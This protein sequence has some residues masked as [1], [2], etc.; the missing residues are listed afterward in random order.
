MP[1]PL[2]NK[3]FARSG[4]LLADTLVDEEGVSVAG[5][6]QLLAYAY[7]LGTARGRRAGRRAIVVRGNLAALYIA[8]ALTRFQSGIDHNLR[9]AERAGHWGGYR[10]YVHHAEAS[11]VAEEPILDGREDHR[12]SRTGGIESTVGAALVGNRVQLVY[13]SHEGLAGRVAGHAARAEEADAIGAVIGT[14]IGATATGPQ[15]VLREGH[16]RAGLDGDRLGAF[17]TDRDTILKGWAEGHG[18][19]SGGSADVLNVSTSDY[20]CIVSS[21]LWRCA[22]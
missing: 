20:W 4:C 6:V 2:W 15:S 5:N 1:F 11:E 12:G 19:I 18:D 14:G 13:R 8:E 10:A 9:V 16:L 21:R 7:N 17:G 3:P 22:N